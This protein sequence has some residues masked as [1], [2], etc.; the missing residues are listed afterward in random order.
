M[1]GVW[2]VAVRPVRLRWS[3]LR[4]VFAACGLTLGWVTTDVV[5]GLLVDQTRLRLLTTYLL[6]AFAAAVLFALWR[7]GLQ[8]TGRAHPAAFAAGGSFLIAAAGC[9]LF[10]TFRSDPYLNLEGNPY[11]RS[12]LDTTRH[13]YWLVYALVV[14][15][16]G[17]F[18]GAFVTAWWAFLRHRDAIAGSVR[19][20]APRSCPEFL[21]AA[22]GGGGLTYR[23][24]LFPLRPAEIP[25]PY[26]SV[27][28]AALAVSFGT[29]LL[30]FWLAGEW[31]D[32]VPAGASLRGAVL[33]IGV[34]GTMFAYFA[35]L[36]RAWHRDRSGG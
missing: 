19:A 11:I 20:A 22:T 14:A 8:G 10:V 2:E 13:P 24:W 27:W 9:D 1:A 15:T 5:Y 30:R 18:V 35:W 36:A 7:F 34:C 32:V 23:Q 16:Q 29:S 17:L 31:L 25:D 4:A 21:K 28:P 3:P 12:L 26:H 33:G 6:P